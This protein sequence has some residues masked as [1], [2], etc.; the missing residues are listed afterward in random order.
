LLPGNPGNGEV[1]GEEPAA[2]ETPVTTINVVVVTQRIS[3]GDTVEEGMVELVD[4]PQE[5]YVEGTYTS[6]EDVYGKIAKFD[7]ESKVFLNSSMVVDSA[8]KLGDSGSDAALLI[9]PEKVAVS[10]PITRLSSVSYGIRRGDRVNVIVTLLMTDLDTEFQSKLPNESSAV[11]APGPVIVAGSESSSAS[12]GGDGQETSKDVTAEIISDE[13]LQSLTSQILSGGA[14]SPIGRLELDPSLGQPFYVVPSEE[15]RPRAISQ[16]L[17][18]DAM[19][20]Q[21]GTFPYDVVP[22][23][24]TPTPE[25]GGDEGDVAVEPVVVQPNDRAS[26]VTSAPDIVTLVVTP[27]EA[28]TLNFLLYQ[29]A[30]LSLALRPV[31]DDS[32]VDTE[33]VTLEFL[34]R[35]Y[36]IAPPAKHPYGLEPRIDELIPPTLRND[37]LQEQ[38]QN[39]GQ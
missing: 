20:L 11:I 22:A 8:D 9:D 7:L 15:Q 38:Q 17:I 6:L 5:L 29:G 10:I 31:K 14:L 33:A 28:V 24:P 16:T 32:R 30:E 21:V 37:A 36:G 19:V 23:E 2:A 34:A 12:S 1:A 13:L 4:I 35:Q 18:Q 39:S 3:R 25:G 26:L 27:Q